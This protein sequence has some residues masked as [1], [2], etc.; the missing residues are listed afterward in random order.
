MVLCGMSGVSWLNEFHVSAFYRVLPGETKGET[1]ITQ[2]DMLDPS[3]NWYGVAD[4]IMAE[5]FGD[6]D[7][8]VQIKMAAK[9]LA[10][11]INAM[12]FCFL[13]PETREEWVSMLREESKRYSIKQESPEHD[14]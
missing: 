6:E 4:L 12:S 8:V 1:N 10:N 3:N 2:R 13:D 9:V 14:A 11:P 5:D 7:S